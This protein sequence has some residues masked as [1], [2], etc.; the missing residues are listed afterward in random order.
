MNR[1]RR[2]DAFLPNLPASLP[3]VEANETGPTPCSNAVRADLKAYA[4]HELNPLRR[5]LVHVHL[6]KCPAC[7]GELADMK[8]ITELFASASAAEGD[9]AFA[10]QLRSRVLSRL[11]GLAPAGA[12]SVTPIRP[13]PLWRKQPALVF[14][15]GGTV[16][17][18]S[19]ALFVTMNHS[20]T[21]NAQTQ[22][23]AGIAALKDVPDYS[24]KPP[25]VVS[26][27]NSAVATA[28]PSATGGS[29]A[30][31]EAEY[32]VSSPG[33]PTRSVAVPATPLRRLRAGN[34]ISVGGSARG[35]ASAAAPAP[36]SMKSFPLAE[37][38]SANSMRARAKMPSQGMVTNQ[39]FAVPGGAAAGKFDA[40]AANMDDGRQVHKEASL[41]LRVEPGGLQTASD[42][43][44]ELVKSTGGF[45][46]SNNLS[47]DDATGE[48]S[49]DL[50]LRV[51]VKDFESVMASLAKMGNVVSKQLTGE[52]ITEKTTDA[53]TAEQVLVNE[54]QETAQKLARQSM[55]EKRT[56]QK[57]AELRQIRM[58]LAQTRSRLGLLRKMAALS[59]IN[60]SLTEKPVKKVVAPPVSHGG[61]FTGM[62]ET[63]HAAMQAFQ[64]AVRVPLVLIVW[65][66][67][68]SPIWVPLIIAYRW[69]SL[70][71]L[72]NRVVASPP[73]SG[74]E[75]AG[76]G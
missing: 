5:A 51:P 31:A 9:A 67:A 58:Q 3:P 44:E 12:A 29:S 59:T 13:T 21:P 66:L 57:E 27:K 25:I 46:S 50:T 68:F 20:Q 6:H 65:I 18:A 60:V 61:F 34:D 72:A 15:G 45:V 39:P 32:S 30:S 23:A 7:R 63:N 11:D 37:P 49:T 69:A 64:T 19:L 17:A 14:G 40:F 10:P 8:K 16:L 56:G 2:D 22:A 38:V 28:A 43:V 73:S 47:T 33:A 53:N 24:E 55:S 1:F 54:A 70:K 48:K 42:K 36:S 62:Q 26:A 75:E 71:T 76:N 41:G 35:S 74:D 4:D 52:D